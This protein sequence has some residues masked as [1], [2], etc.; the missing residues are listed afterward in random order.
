M[1]DIYILD[2]KDTLKRANARKA[3]ALVHSGRRTWR[4]LVWMSSTLAAVICG[5]QGGGGT[6]A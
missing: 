1:A 3:T 6:T 5:R 2:I 4:V